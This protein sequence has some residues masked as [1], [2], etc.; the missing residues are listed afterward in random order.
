MSKLLYDDSSIV[1]RIGENLIRSISFRF[2]ISNSI[3]RRISVN[4]VFLKR[5]SEGRRESEF[6][7]M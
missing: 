6:E 4:W 7:K 5:Y 1:A 3:S 2:N